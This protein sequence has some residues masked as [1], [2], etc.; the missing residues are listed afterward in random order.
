MKL[1][2]PLLFL[3]LVSSAQ[4]AE[5][6][7]FFGGAQSKTAALDRC[8]P[9]FEN[10]GYADG[11]VQ[12]VIDEIRAHPENH[13][14]VVGHSSGAAYANTVARAVAL[15]FKGDRRQKARAPVADRITLIDLDGFAP[16]SV[17]ASVPR[18]CWHA[19]GG[20]SGKLVSRNYSSMS[21]DNN[22]SEVHTYEDSHCKTVWCLHFTLVNPR[23]PATIAGGYWTGGRKGVG[24]YV[25]ATWV[26]HGYDNCSQ[27]SLPW[28]SR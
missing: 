6:V 23:T 8:F 2:T 9:G 12:R 16:R 19:K 27:S 18:K 17:P 11:S 10:H 5:K 14:T 22:C 3:C 4:A 28:L 1:L 20:T 21:A 26:P 13:Y 7:I 25:P 24:R 15:G